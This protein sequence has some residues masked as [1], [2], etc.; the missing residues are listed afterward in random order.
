MPDHRA[1]PRRA[2]SV[3]DARDDDP[4]LS[5]TAYP[6]QRAAVELLSLGMIHLRASGWV[7]P[8][9]PPPFD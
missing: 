8:I 1:P 5:A 9:T 6:R 7:E 4:R 3:W 2:C